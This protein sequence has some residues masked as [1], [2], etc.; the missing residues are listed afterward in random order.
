MRHAVV[1]RG[2]GVAVGREVHGE[3]LNGLWGTGD[4]LPIVGRELGAHGR[5]VCV[6]A[7]EGGRPHDRARSGGEDRRSW[8]KPTG[9]D[10]ADRKCAAKH[11]IV[12]QGGVS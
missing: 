11:R 7:A 12:V 9:G 5:R 8:R 10:A 4:R 6:A 3:V 1:V 2:D